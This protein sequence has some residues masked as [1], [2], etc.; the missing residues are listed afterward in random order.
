MISKFAKV[1]Q[2]GAALGV[3]NSAAY[4]S[5]FIGGSLAGLLIGSSERA[6]IGISVGVVAVVWLLWTFTLQNPI[7]YSHLVVPMAEVD[8][9]KLKELEHEH[10]AE[11]FI[12]DTEKVVIVKYNAKELSE[13]DLKFK[14]A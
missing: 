4:F 5:T 9:D 12:N 10:I 11:W 14:I 1:H 2:K 8:M 7:R 13:D 6:T 3:A